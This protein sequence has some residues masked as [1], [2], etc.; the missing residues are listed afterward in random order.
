MAARLR[1]FSLSL[2][3]FLLLQ[4]TPLV[5]C[6][7]IPIVVKSSVDKL[8]V[9]LDESVTFKVEIIGDLSADTKIELPGLK[10]IFDI[11]ST[12]QSQSLS[13]SGKENNR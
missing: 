2:S 5:F 11:I 9:T 4:V 8:K 10:N 13:I 12:V 3:C 6:A 7:D 1:L